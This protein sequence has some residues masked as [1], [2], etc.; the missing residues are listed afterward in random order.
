MDECQPEREIFLKKKTPFVQGSHGR[1]ERGKRKK[2]K[3]DDG[4]KIDG[5]EGW[6]G[7]DG[8]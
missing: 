5:G 2:S 1:F 6:D 7:K 8:I 3:I 4:E